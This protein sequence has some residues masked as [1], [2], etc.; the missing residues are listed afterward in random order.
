MAERVS[1]SVGVDIFEERERGDNA[2]LVVPGREAKS[3]K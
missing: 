1:L 2:I 3:E